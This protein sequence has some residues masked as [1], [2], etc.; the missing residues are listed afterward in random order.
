[1]EKYEILKNL[2]KFNTIDDKEN[3]EILYY[4]E[5]LLLEK[6][7]NVEFKDKV[8]IMSNDKKAPLGFLGHTDTVEYT[9]GWKN[10]PFELTIKN[11]LI[12]GLGTC[13]M[14]GGIAAIL[15]AIIETDFHKLKHGIKLYFTYNE[16]AGGFGGINDLISMNEEFPNTIIFGEPTNNEI[17]VGSKGLLELELNFKGKKAHASNPKRGKNANTNAIKMLYQLNR[18]YEE[19]IKIEQDEK[20]EVPYTTMNI[21]IINGGTGINSIP[22][23]CYATIDF[24]TIKTEHTTFILNKIKELNNNYEFDYK[25]LGM[26]EPFYNEIDGIDSK[27]TSNFITEASLIKNRNRIILGLGPVTAHEINEHI[28]EESYQKLVEQYKSIIIKYC[29]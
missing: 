23:N 12:Y 16:E 19:N 25:I 5:K 15:D 22:D 28:T 2:V 1:M 9:N 27:K 13:D 18:F 24:R 4:I 20:Y 7:F 29:K 26:I 3:K 11:G 6:G 8:L 14:K 17:L 21:G 10:N